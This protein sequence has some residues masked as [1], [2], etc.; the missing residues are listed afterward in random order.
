MAA[1]AVRVTRPKTEKGHFDQF[2]PTGLS[3]G[4][5]IGQSTFAAT[6]PIGCRA[7]LPA[8]PG[9]AIELPESTLSG[10]SA[11]RRDSRTVRASH[12]A[13]HPIQA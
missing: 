5:R 3:V 7:P 13:V 4:Y 9:V 6:S 1:R 11:R 10:H 12:H 8:I 2:P